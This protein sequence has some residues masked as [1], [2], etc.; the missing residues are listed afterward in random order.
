MDA[1]SPSTVFVTATRKVSPSRRRMSGEGSVPLT[2]MARPVL[3]PTVK[4]AGPMVRAILS[5]ER[6]F[7]SRKTPWVPLR[8]QEG[9]RLERLRLA[10]PNDP[11]CS[12][13]GRYARKRDEAGQR[14]T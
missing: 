11:A 3:P 4:G 6:T 1:S 14:G 12:R 10:A 2:V 7:G 8:A 9:K 13:F 5:Q